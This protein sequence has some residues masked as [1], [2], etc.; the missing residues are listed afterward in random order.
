MDIATL[1]LKVESDDVNRATASLSRLTTTATAAERAA[2]RWGVASTNAADAAFSR[3]QKLPGTLNSGAAAASSM[4]SAMGLIARF[5]G[6]LALIAAILGTV[7]KAW[8]AGMQAGDIGEVASQL[9]LTTDQLQAYRFEAGQAGIETGQMDA[10]MIRFTNTMGAAFKGGEEQIKF[11]EKLGVKILDA[12]GNLRSAGDVIPEVSKGLLT[13]RSETE[14]N[15]L[16]ADGFGRSGARMVNMLEKWAG[17]NAALIASVRE[18]GGIL[19]GEVIKSWDDVKDAMVRAERAATVTFAKL[20]APIATHFLKQVEGI[21][22]SISWA[23][24]KAG[25]AWKFVTGALETSTADLTTRQQ[26]IAATIASLEGTTDPLDLARLAGLKRSLT[27]VNELLA[28]RATPVLPPITVTA[29]PP[30][31][32]T[33]N[34]APK[35]SGDAYAKI[36][37]QAKSYIA[38][39]Q[40]ET[41]AI[42]MNADAAARLV[43][44]TELLNKAREANLKLGPAQ[45]AQLKDLAN[46]MAEAENRFKSSKFMNDNSQAATQFVA[47]QQLEK[48]A[49]FM[50]TQAADQ[51]RFAQEMLN[52]AQND[53]IILTPQ[54]T[55]KIQE[56]AGSMAAAKA[57]TDNYKEAVGFAKDVVKGAFSD[58]NNSL[59]QGATLWE[60]LGNAATGVLTK[61]SD[62]LMDMA[63]NQLFASAFGGSGGG[64]GLMSLLGG[65]GGA[66]GSTAPGALDGIFTSLMGSP[67][68]F[69]G[70]GSTP[71][72]TPYVVGENGP[73]VRV[74]GPGR[75][76]N[77]NQWGAATRGGGSGSHITVSIQLDDAMLRAT[78]RDEAG[79][80]IAVSSPHIVGKAV[81]ISKDQ[82]VPTMNKH[83]AERGGDYRDN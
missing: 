15:A 56:L 36:I 14:R 40:V 4:A 83:H 81:S 12:N 1:G 35:G 27:E 41:Q 48:D 67:F 21:M 16:M 5:A 63:V 31:V 64:G 26:T 30:S 49:L 47:G 33:G 71:V 9:N 23:A 50:S 28:N 17:G 73:E 39:K 66:A 52:K 6:P 68:M 10:A 22:L 72:G 2:Q 45:I 13:M 80:E 53:N 76:Y 55:A 79:K 32:G 24:D 62:K 51:M 61:I 70:G 37:E 7:N 69:A 65:M 25:S 54:Q 82:V 44:E 42:G 8:E 34:P 38:Q 46:G 29:P 43:H 60:A 3:F 11:F 20:G 78:A 19:D 75:I 57:S 77:A 74:D 18:Q 59:R 58:M